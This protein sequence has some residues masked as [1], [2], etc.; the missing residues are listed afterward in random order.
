MRRVDQPAAFAEAHAACR[1]EAKAAY[2]D[3]RVLLER[4]IE[5]P[6][7]VEVQ[8]FADRHGNAVH[9]CERDCSLQRRHQKVIEEAPASTLTPELRQALGAAAVKAALA[10]RYENAGTVEFLLDPDGG[11]H[12]I[13]MNTRLQVEHPVTEMITGQDLVEWQLRIASGEPL[14]LRQDQI[15][16]HGHAVEARLYAEDPTRGFLPSTGRL[17]RLVL[18]EGL[19]G[20]RVDTGVRAGDEVTPFYDPMIAKIVAH[21]PDRSRALDLLARALEATEVEGP[22]TNLAFLQ[23]IV[24]AEPYRRLA[25]DTGWLDREGA[26]LASAE[27]LPSALDAA[28]AALA[29]IADR[30]E[31]ALAKRGAAGGDPASPWHDLS[32]WQLNAPAMQTVR[33]R[34]REPVLIV[35]GRSH[36][37]LGVGDRRWTAHHGCVDGVCWVEI[38]GHRTSYRA[39][40]S[41]GTVSMVR[42]GRRLRLLLEADEAAVGSAEADEALIAAPMPGKVMRLLVAEGDRVARGETL[43]ILEAMKMEHRLAAPH[44][45][46]VS[47]L[48]VVEG[49]QIQEGKVL[50]DLDRAE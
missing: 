47:A 5:R 22:S 43:A 49:E 46:R 7:H 39:S 9:L 48:H 18:P 12:F 50:L 38:D 35:T 44:D 10:S 29:V 30:K 40:V 16:P 45:G 27:D 28:L 36:V 13:E 37:E 41:G 2:G 3:D 11:F 6:R 20:I 17:S 26:L 19:P 34:G 21:G 31:R 33:F 23:R 42:D 32:G 14:P 4:L 8:V 24:R 25:I 1:S 15:V